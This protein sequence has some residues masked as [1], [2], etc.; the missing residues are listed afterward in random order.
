VGLSTNAMSALRRAVAR[1]LRRREPA[2]AA[3][4]ALTWDADKRASSSHAIPSTK[5]LEHIR[6]LVQLLV[7]RRRVVLK[8]E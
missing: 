3:C 8:G 5:G 7:R 2:F 1:R 4:P 6:C